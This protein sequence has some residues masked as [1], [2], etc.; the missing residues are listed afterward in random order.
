MKKACQFYVSVGKFDIWEGTRELNLRGIRFFMGRMGDCVA[1][2]SQ[3]AG[4]CSLSVIDWK[5]SEYLD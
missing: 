1:K 3:F 4:R 2:K 5:R